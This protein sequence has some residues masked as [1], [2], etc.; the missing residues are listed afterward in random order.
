MNFTRKPRIAIPEPC[1]EQWDSMTS[2]DKGKFCLSCQETVIDFTHYSDN[3]LLLFFSH[4]KTPVCGRFATDQLERSLLDSSSK[5]TFPI[6]KWITASIISIPLFSLPKMTTAN[7]KPTMHQVLEDSVVNNLADS[8][9]TPLASVQGD[10]SPIKVI[11]ST[12]GTINLSTNLLPVDLDRFPQT[13]AGTALPY[14]FYPRPFI[15]NFPSITSYAVV[16]VKTLFDYLT[17]KDRFKNFDQ[18]PLFWKMILGFYQQLTPKKDVEQ[19]LG[20]ANS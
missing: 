18:Q 13:T 15:F 5:K 11:E 1:H 3:Q 7:L 12:I 4:Q 6:A 19:Q 16:S 9:V 2:T 10:S 14:D 20:E 8:I 17:L